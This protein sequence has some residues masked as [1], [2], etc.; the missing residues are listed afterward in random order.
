MAHF[1]NQPIHS[2]FKY[3]LS[4]ETI[5]YLKMP[6]FNIWHWESNEVLFIDKN[7]FFNRLYLLSKLKMLSLLEH[8]F[9]EL[10]LVSEFNINQIILKRWLVCKQILNSL[11]LL[12]SLTSVFIP[13]QCL[14]KAPLKLKA[15]KAFYL[16]NLT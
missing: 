4:A 5:E 1:Y 7:T 2:Y 3:Q 16:T 14:P 15:K 11:N 9:Y 12:T 13:Q 6:T 8:M 10:G